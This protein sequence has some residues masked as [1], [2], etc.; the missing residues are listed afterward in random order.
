MSTAASP[1]NPDQ[2]RAALSFLFVPW[3]RPDRFGSATTANADLIVLD[4]EDAVA[5]QDKSAARDHVV[6]WLSAGHRAIVRIKARGTEW[7]EHDL[8][9]IRA[10][11][12]AD[13]EVPRWARSH[14]VAASAAARVTPPVDGVTTSI[15][16]TSVLQRDCE[17]SVRLGF[18]GKLC[19]H[20]AQVPLVHQ[21]FAP[22][23]D[24][25]QWATRRI[26]ASKTAAVTTLDGH[27]VDAPV[28]ERARTILDRTGRS[29]PSPSTHR[30]AEE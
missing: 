12:S 20:P 28:I 5:P 2:L 24:D 22:T 18:G 19:I 6:S 14:L 3:S 10:N 8:K 30:K 11:A 7:F 13:H 1:P 4:L 29:T 23:S 27:M 17:W 9:A 15:D 16:Q 25:I 26:E 21:Y